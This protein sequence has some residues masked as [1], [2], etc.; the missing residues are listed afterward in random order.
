M[1]QGDICM[2]F[3]DPSRQQM[4]YRPCWEKANVA[5]PDVMIEISKEPQKFRARVMVPSGKFNSGHWLETEPIGLT[6]V[7]KLLIDWHDDPEGAVW[8]HFKELPPNSAAW[9]EGRREG[10]QVSEKVLV[11]AGDIN[12]DDLGGL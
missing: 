7:A 12:I 10:R 5:L 2:L 9:T 8:K 1:K 11:P 6:E 3:H 4:G